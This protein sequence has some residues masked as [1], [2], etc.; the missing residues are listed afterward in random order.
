MHALTCTSP[1]IK[2]ASNSCLIVYFTGQVKISDA[3][4]ITLYI[5]FMKKLHI[6]SSYWLV[7][8]LCRVLGKGQCTD[9]HSNTIFMFYILKIKDLKRK[10][11][12]VRQP[13]C[14]KPVSTNNLHSN[15]S[16]A[17][18]CIKPS[19]WEGWVPRKSNQARKG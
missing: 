17:C 16:V 10:P 9:A 7:P 13:E 6:G 4:L 3:V 12:F 8:I 19:I 5:L 15:V 11:D 14:C 18:Q 2:K 1:K